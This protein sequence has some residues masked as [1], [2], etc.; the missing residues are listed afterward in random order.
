MKRYIPLLLILIGACKPDMPKM[1]A[2]IL[3]L[4]KMK[5]ILADMHIADAVAETKAKGGANEG[6]VTRALYAQIYKNNGIT[7]DQ[8]KQSYQFYLAHPAWQNKL[9]EE[10]LTELSKRESDVS[11]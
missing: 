3:P 4:T 5:M 2:D 7:E 6:E 9:Y 8:F 1:P 11:K 10:I